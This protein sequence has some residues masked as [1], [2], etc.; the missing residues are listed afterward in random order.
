M[1]KF[2]VARL[3]KE[4]IELAGSEPA[5]FLGLASGDV[6]SAASS[7]DYDLLVSRVS[8][9]ALVSGS[10]RVTIAGECGRCL[11]PVEREIAAENI[12]LFIALPQTAEEIDISED[13]RSEVLLELPM[14]LLCKEDCRGLCP[15]CG[16]D[17]NR[18]KCGCSGTPGGALAWGELDKLNL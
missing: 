7:V 4:P 9:G 16:A 12:E 2:S 1:I 8:G 17:L 3:D 18:C 13:I 11:A 10:C 15:R 6:Y 5:E 14:I